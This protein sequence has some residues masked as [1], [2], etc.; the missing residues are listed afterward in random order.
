MRTYRITWIH[1]KIL[2]GTRLESHLIKAIYRRWKR[3]KN[4]FEFAQKSNIQLQNHF[5]S[6][7]STIYSC[8]CSA[9][10]LPMQR[11]LFI[12]ISSFQICFSFFLSAV[13][14]VSSSATMSVITTVIYR[15]FF[16]VAVE[17]FIILFTSRQMTKY[18]WRYNEFIK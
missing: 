4:S 13:F 3:Q 2:N 11:L 7:N 14:L 9:I 5:L 15:V 10:L 1:I 17:D 6:P 16:F 8:S 18:M 12:F